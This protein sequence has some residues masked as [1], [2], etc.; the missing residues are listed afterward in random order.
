MSKVQLENRADTTTFLLVAWPTGCDQVWGPYLL[1]ALF[2]DNAF[3]S[4]I[5][6]KVFKKNP[7]SPKILFLA[8]YCKVTYKKK[9]CQALWQWA[10]LYK[11]LKIY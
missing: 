9:R 7:I 6:N 3:L 10:K 11:S 8:L 4:Y 2:T 1:R 5:E